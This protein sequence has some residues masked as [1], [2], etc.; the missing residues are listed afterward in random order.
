MIAVSKEALQESVVQVLAALSNIGA[1][2]INMTDRLIEDLGLDSLKRMEALARVADQYGVDPDIEKVMGVRT[3]GD[4][5]ALM[6][7]QVPAPAPAQA[8]ACVCTIGAPRAR[9]E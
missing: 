4:V 6:E 1:E 7:A 3:V 8:A 5:F 2:K 9:A